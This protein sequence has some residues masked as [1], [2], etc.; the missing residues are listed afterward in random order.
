M[1]CP[2]GF[3]ESFPHVNFSLSRIVLRPGDQNVLISLLLSTATRHVAK[4]AGD[5]GVSD[6]P[7]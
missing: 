2:L 5:S 7:F 4:R 6:I 1:V 3:D